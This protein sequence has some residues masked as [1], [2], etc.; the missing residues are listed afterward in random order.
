M[1]FLT[2]LPAALSSVILEEWLPFAAIGFVDS[3][4][5]CRFSR[6]EF[7]ALL[8]DTSFSARGFKTGYS[9]ILMRW[10]R[11]IKVKVRAFH[12]D[13]ACSFAL[14]DLYAVYLKDLRGLKEL[15]V[16]YSK[17]ERSMVRM[18]QQQFLLSQLRVLS[19]DYKSVASIVPIANI[20][21]AARNSLTK[22]SLFWP[23]G[24]VLLPDSLAL[25]QQLQSLAQR[26]VNDIVIDSITTSCP[27]ICNLDISG[28]PY[29]TDSGFQKVISNLDALRSIS[30]AVVPW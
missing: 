9:H 7:L 19:V 1:N 5:C 27:R 15:Y 18:L 30:V 17:A 2:S 25:C 12:F 11:M 3:A 24:G 13:D 14:F 10:F 21:S 8:E 4:H 29:V 28:S 26:G 20:I 23:W 6:G 16:H 22:A